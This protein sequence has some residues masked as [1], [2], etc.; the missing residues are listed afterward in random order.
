MTSPVATDP[1]TYTT[2]T[3]E[4]DEL[5]LTFASDLGEGESV[6]SAVCT[7]IRADTGASAPTGLN[8]AAEVASP[9]VTQGFD[10]RNLS[11]GTYRLIWDATLNTG[12]HRAAFTLLVLDF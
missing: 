11:Q 9:V 5:S 12:A 10:A 8:G 3:K 2:N 7:L 1:P 6:A 4:L